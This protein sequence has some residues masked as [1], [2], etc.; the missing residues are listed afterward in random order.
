MTEVVFGKGRKDELVTIQAGRAIAALLV[1]AFHTSIS[2]FALPKYFSDQPFGRLF[3]FGHSG[4]DFFFVLSG[5]IILYV[6]STD[7]GRSEKLRPY[8]FKRLIRIYPIYWIILGT[9][10]P[11][12]VM[13]RSF[14]GGHELE[15]LTLLSSFLLVHFGNHGGVLVVSWTLFHEVLFYCV[16]GL[17]ILL[18][19][20]GLSLIVGWSLCCFWDLLHASDVAI[21]ARTDFYFS[22]YNLLFIIGLSCAWILRRH[23]IRAPL[24]FVLIGTILFVATGVEE[25]FFQILSEAIRLVL[26]GLGS[27]ISIL[28]AVE[29]DRAKHIRMPR[30]IA[31][32]GEASYSIY[33]AHFMVLSM[34]A[35]LWAHLGANTF[36]PN[37]LSFLMLFV[38]TVGISCIIHRSVEKPVLSVLRRLISKPLDQAR[39]A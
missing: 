31:F 25:D 39:T 18:P 38:V 13:N 21:K 16:F 11:A 4:V 17:I 7:I 1:V 29:L 2:I 28:G 34:A 20:I 10:L 9:T 5:F 19:R 12:Y 27:A 24:G 6:H 23:R 37:G 30:W 15:P 33:L 32:I 35:K 3:D 22:P 26:Y 14:G 8:L 36:V